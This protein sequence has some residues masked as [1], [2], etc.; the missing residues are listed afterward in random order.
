MIMC[1]NNKIKKYSGFKM[2]CRCLN[3]RS[4]NVVLD[5]TYIP[6]TTMWIILVILVGQLTVLEPIMRPG[7]LTKEISLWPND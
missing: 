3:T 6:I 4:L 1:N 7:H 2:F 5:L